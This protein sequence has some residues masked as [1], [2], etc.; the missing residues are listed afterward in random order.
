MDILKPKRGE[1]WWV[2]FDP[3]IGSESKKIRPAVV[4]SNDYSNKHV[5]RFQVVPLTS[6]VSNIYPS[7]CIVTIKS[8][9]SKIMADQLKTVDASR[10]IRK[11]DTLTKENMSLVEQTIRLQ[12]GLI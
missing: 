6:N 12:L 11:V 10:M 1:V 2:N 9:Q 5:Q 3:S 7:N 8:Q 4:V